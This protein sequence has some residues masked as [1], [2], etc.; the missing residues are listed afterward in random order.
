MQLADGTRL[1]GVDG[2]EDALPLFLAE[3]SRV[4]VAQGLQCRQRDVRDGPVDEL[5]QQRD[6][7]RVARSAEHFGTVF[8][9]DERTCRPKLAQRTQ[10]VLRQVGRE[11]ADEQDPVVVPGVLDVAV[12]LRELSVERLERA[13]PKLP[14]GRSGT[15]RTSTLSTAR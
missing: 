1:R 3:E 9:P 8:L 10:I 12:A 5:E 14:G 13:H 7:P 15:R 4:E 6:S 2:T 11:L